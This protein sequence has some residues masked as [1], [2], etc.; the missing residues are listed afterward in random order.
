[1]AFEKLNFLG[2]PVLET[3]R[4][5]LRRLK[6]SDA[7]DMFE[8]AMHRDVSKYV[9]WEPHESIERAEKFIK[10]TIEHY[11][12]D[13]SGE[14]GMEL[15]ENGK[16][17][18]SMGFV[19]FNPQDLCG[20]IGYTLSRDYWGKGI[21]TEAVKCIIRFAFEEMKINRIEAVHFSENEASGR[22]MQKA[23]MSFE[24]LL[25]QRRFA[26]G[27]YWDLKYYAILKSDWN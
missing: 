27:R 1:M 17:I 2:Y 11:D 10:S 19:K 15:K 16:L 4:L 25:R 23:G 9:S 3:E 5:I 20:E 6:T 24:G 26:K 14:L 12:N 13:E 18:G 7:Q 22:V 21:M 8:F